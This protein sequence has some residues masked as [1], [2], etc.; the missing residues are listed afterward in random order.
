MR[1]R[2]EL[3]FIH[4]AFITILSDYYNEYITLEEKSTQLVLINF[5]FALT[6]AGEIRVTPNN[7]K[8]FSHIMK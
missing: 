4:I 6:K 2:L 3:K 8:F 1:S 7:M 5:N